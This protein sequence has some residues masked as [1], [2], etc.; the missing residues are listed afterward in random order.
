M[1]PPS[2][3]VV[4]KIMKKNLFFAIVV[5]VL[6]LVSC[7]SNDNSSN[8]KLTEFDEKLVEDYRANGCPFAINPF[9]PWYDAYLFEGEGEYIIKYAML[10]PSYK[11]D[12]I[13]KG[14]LG[15]LKK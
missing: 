5:V 11:K 3:G 15:K 8:I 4:Y 2:G 7:S 6:S 14:W 10:S 9:E 1:Y 13:E 12:G